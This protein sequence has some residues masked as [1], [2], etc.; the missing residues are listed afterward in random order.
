MFLLID[1]Y[2]EHNEYMKAE[3]AISYLEELQ[4]KYKRH[5]I[6]ENDDPIENKKEFPDVFE[7]SKYFN[8][9]TFGSLVSKPERLPLKICAEEL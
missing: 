5:L 9:F 8:I 1:C 6:H 3:K 4:E 2:F 7:R